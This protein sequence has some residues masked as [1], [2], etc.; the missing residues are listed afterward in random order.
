MTS[1]L[2]T[3]AAGFIG[4]RLVARLRESGHDVHEVDRPEGDVAD[5]ATWRAF[6]RTDVVVHLAGRHFVP[7]SWTAPAAFIHT[8]VLGAVQAL[9]F[10]KTN[11]ARVV[12]LSSY[13]YGNPAVQPIPET[14]PIVATN[15]YAL[16]KK[17]AEEACRFYAERFGVP[18]T[19]F[20]PFNVYG[21]GQADQFLVPT[22]IKQV[23]EGRE[24]R[25]LDLEPRRDFVFLEDVV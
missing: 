17:L 20:R 21:P 7:E 11:S 23:A 4:K 6:P 18:V 25:V 1:V 2:V 19:V 5:E 10:A 8:N 12:Y 13:L 3:G 15:P 9:G 24:I 22:I 16:S 14:A